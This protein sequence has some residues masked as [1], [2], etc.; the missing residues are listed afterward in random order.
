MK[1][2]FL[3]LKNNYDSNVK[4][5]INDLGCEILFIDT[6]LDI[7]VAVKSEKSISELM[8][9]EEI[10]SVREFDSIKL[11]E[12]YGEITRLRHNMLVHSCLY[13]RLNTNIISDHKFDSMAKKL[14]ELQLLYPEIASECVYHEYFDGFDGSSGYDLP[15]HLDE[16][17]QRTLK[18]LNYHN[19]KNNQN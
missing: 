10:K 1:H 9:Y 3:T 12:H 14:A 18:L 17:I 19:R 7:L 4:E 15:Y 6:T 13:Y 8:K 11:N 2:Y 5:K 16:V